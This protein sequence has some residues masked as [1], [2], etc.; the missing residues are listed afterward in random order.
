MHIYAIFL[1]NIDVFESS[2]IVDNLE[3]DSNPI[4]NSK[5]ET[6]NKVVSR[7]DS[8]GRAKVD[9]MKLV[10]EAFRIRKPFKE[11]IIKKLIILQ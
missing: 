5:K 11:K 3:E 7:R 10:Y 8:R 1:S 2:L 4:F 9:L 6:K